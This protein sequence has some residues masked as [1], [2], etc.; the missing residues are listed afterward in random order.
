MALGEDV[1]KTY[2]SGR[3]LLAILW[4]TGLTLQSLSAQ[5]ARLAST[6]VKISLIRQS[7]IPARDAGILEAI[8]FTE[9]TSVAKGD[10][11]AE[12]ESKQQTL[13][14]Q[15][16]EYALEIA[17]MRAEDTLPLKTAEA[18]LKEAEAG[19]DV[20]KVSLQIA[21][22]EATNTSSVGIA[23]E[24]TRLRELELD[25]ALSSKKTYDGSVSKSQIDRLQTSVNQ[26]KLEV[27]QA[28]DNLA[29]Q[30]LKPQAELA[31]LEK[32]Q[33]EIS[34]YM[35]LLDQEKRNQLV[36]GLTSQLKNNELR[37][38]ELNL[39]HR[40]IRAPFDGIVVKLERQLGE[41]VEPGTPVARIIDVK[42]LRAE[43]FLANTV[44]HQSLVGQ[45]VTINVTSGTNSFAVV[46]K[47]TFVGREVDPQNQEVRFYADFDNAD[48]KALPGMAGS[49]TIRK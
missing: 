36:A 28:K 8:H 23:T 26:S 11:L 44:A 13:Q 24:E 32:K 47:I 16:A 45:D 4:I 14:C 12:L 15:A 29:I 34:R 3:F 41:W 9:G 5:D 42:T 38:A 20:T 31:A 43:G 22:A 17:Q 6:P 48:M 18:Q 30:K 21:E 39:E 46:G 10:V 7:D 40:F 35:S 49:L 25:R 2:N 1:M 19:R 37:M 33:Q 27:Q